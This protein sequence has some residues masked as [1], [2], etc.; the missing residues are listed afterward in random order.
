MELK[1]KIIKLNNEINE[2]LYEYQTELNTA[3]YEELLLCKEKLNTIIKVYLKN[4]E[5]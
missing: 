4:S 3:W 2:I 1:G 5:K